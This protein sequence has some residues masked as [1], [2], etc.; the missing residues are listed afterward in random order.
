MV[1]DAHHR[2]AQEGLDREAQPQFADPEQG[3]RKHRFGGPEPAPQEEGECRDGREDEGDDDRRR[4]CVPLAAPVRHQEQGAG[5]RGRERA[6][7]GVRRAFDL[8]EKGLSG[9]TVKA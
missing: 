2:A 8:V 4:P 6:A 1:D 9:Y 7:E 3:G 5:E